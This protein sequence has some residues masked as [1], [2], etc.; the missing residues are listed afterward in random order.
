M[1]F[2]NVWRF[3]RKRGQSMYYLCIFLVAV[4]IA[5][6]I[7][8]RNWDRVVFTDAHVWI[9]DIIVGVVAAGVWLFLNHL[10]EKFLS[11]SGWWWLVYEGFLVLGAFFLLRGTR[12]V[13][14][15]C[16]R[17][18]VYG[19]NGLE[20]PDLLD[21]QNLVPPW[22][23]VYEAADNTADTKW[24]MVKGEW[25]WRRDAM[26]STLIL[27]VLFVPTFLL[28]CLVE[29]PHFLV[30]V[31]WVKTG[32]RIVATGST[33]VSTPFEDYLEEEKAVEHRPFYPETCRFRID[34]PGN[35]S[36]IEV[37]M[38]LESTLRQNPEVWTRTPYTTPNFGIWH[39]RKHEFYQQFR[40]EPWVLRL[41][42]RRVDQHGFVHKTYIR[43][44]VDCADRGHGASG[45]TVVSAA[46]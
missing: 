41:N 10:N 2:R 5:L 45:A 32:A 44:M 35:P 1:V 13:V 40:R 9:S 21:G 12:K 3:Y 38:V 28:H 27:M 23:D 11:D 14:P 17:W 18:R 43:L 37:D 15:P 7:F 36:L 20:D 29:N 25:Q 8:R 42:L 34:P 26:R 33:T 6:M 31:S 30:G 4:F 24:E 22:K 19:F 16:R 39:L 46:P